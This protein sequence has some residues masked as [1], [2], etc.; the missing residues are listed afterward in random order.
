[1]KVPL[2]SL[3]L[4]TL[5]LAGCAGTPAVPDQPEVLSA[6]RAAAGAVSIS[7]HEFRFDSTQDA[8]RRGV[9]DFAITNQGNEHHEFVIVPY[10]DGR[11]GEPVAEHEAL[12]P[13]ESGVL[14]VSLN[15]GRYRL[16]CL[17]VTVKP[18]GPVSH[19]ALGMDRAL[20]V[21]P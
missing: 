18:E 9:V 13:G 14:R 6:D 17:L 8:V 16:V 2:V 5:L 1:M 21:T 15:P 4:A 19:I 11:F 20:E 12:D 7:Q 3:A 10:S